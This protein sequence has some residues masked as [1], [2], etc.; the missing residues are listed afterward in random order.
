MAV[1]IADD[2]RAPARWP[3]LDGI[4]GVAV[5]AVVLFHAVRLTVLGTGSDAGGGAMW[6]PASIA[7][8]GLDAF[9][10]LSGFLIVGSWRSLRRDRPLV[11]A[12]HDY[13]RRRAARILPAYWVSLLVLVPLVARHLLTSP[14]DLAL[15]VGVQQHLRPELPS[16]VNVVYWSLTTEVHFYLLAPLVA[17][18]IARGS[19]RTIVVASLVV[20]VAWQAGLHGSMAP[21]LIPGRIDQFVLGALAG[22]VVRSWDAGARS[23]LVGA[24]AAPW[25][26]PALVVALAAAGVWQG[27]VL[28]GHSLLAPVLHP[29][30]GA[31]MAAGL[32][33]LVTTRRSPALEGRGWRALGLVSYGTYLF[34]YPLLKYGLRW[35]GVTASTPPVVAS[36]V[37]LALVAASFVVGAASYVMV[38]RRFLGRTEPRRMRPPVGWNGPPASPETLRLLVATTR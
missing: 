13:A 16:E 33:R 34:H 12:V 35:A 6:W 24:L 20:A 23:R 18:A 10:V 29:L 22:D 37:V 32:I 9:F 36:A 11:G 8:F 27:A 15:L 3:A 2:L 17:F 38:E 1:T 25:V 5:V 30:V 28:D 31:L 14:G 19:R 26:G 4:R 7:R 21:N